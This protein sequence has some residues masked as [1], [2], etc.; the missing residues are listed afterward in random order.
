[1]LDV[2]FEYVD[3]L[4]PVLQTCAGN[5]KRIYI[6]PTTEVDHTVCSQNKAKEGSIHR[7]FLMNISMDDSITSVV[8]DPRDDVI[9]AFFESTARGESNLIPKE[10]ED[11]SDPNEC[12]RFDES[13]SYQQSLDDQSMGDQSLDHQL[14]S[15]DNERDVENFNRSIQP[16]R[17][18]NRKRSWGVVRMSPRIIHNRA[19][20]HI[21]TWEE[22]YSELCMYH[23]QH[24]DCL[25]H[26][27]DTK[28]GRWVKKQRK[29]HKKRELHYDK[30][31]CLE[32]IG[33]VWEL[34]KG[35]QQQD[36]VDMYEQLKAYKEEIGDCN[37]P[38]RKSKLGR[39]VQMQR[40]RHK[41]GELGDDQ[42][43][44]LE[45]IG[46]AWYAHIQSWMDMYEELK[47]YKEENGDCNVP[48]L[49]PK[50]GRWV[51][52]QREKQKK[53]K[54]D[55]DQIRCLDS[56]GFMWKLRLTWME[57][58][59]ELKRYKEENG[60]CRVPALTPKLGGWVHT[61]RKKHKKGE[62]DDDQ[63]RCLDSIG[64]M[65]KFREAMS[66]E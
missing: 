6:A 56:I 14:S 51:N 27:K 33:F 41:K 66:K 30:I 57:M 12:S 24:G 18:S 63:I 5:T 1:M 34:Q 32:S 43:R 55:D 2:K 11:Q 37:V 44:C 49:T 42:I 45:S 48:L 65:W 60:D 47:A 8:R 10:E 31:R 26:T 58:F 39:W 17:I 50:L 29:S 38:Q 28:L 25:V 23:R 4:Q 36:W 7:T 21:Q 22:M 62:L 53:G 9:K 3:H 61:Q 13:G 64:F 35:G 54:L 15:E 40:E 59:E 46:F 52:K 20:Y 19:T 16:Y